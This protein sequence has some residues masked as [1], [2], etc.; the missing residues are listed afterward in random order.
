MNENTQLLNA[1]PNEETSLSSD[2][3]SNIQPEDLH[4][5]LPD[6]A[7]SESVV[8]TPEEEKSEQITKE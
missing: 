7:P 5:E 6:I 1:I 4:T 2:P 8:P 3:P